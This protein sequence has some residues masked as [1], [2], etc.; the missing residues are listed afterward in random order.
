ME[1]DAFLYTVIDRN[2]DTYDVDERIVLRHNFT[3]E[4]YKS[5]NQ[6]VDD[7][8][9]LVFNSTSSNS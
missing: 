3:N 4:S 6:P 7:K 9:A 5:V 2:E 1:C 8:V